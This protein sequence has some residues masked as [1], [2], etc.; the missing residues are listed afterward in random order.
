VSLYDDIIVNTAVYS[1]LD[2][3]DDS[4][5]LDSAYL[6]GRWITVGEITVGDGCHCMAQV[7]QCALPST[8]K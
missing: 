5:R 7:P 1:F 6:G 4:S 2:F 3:I 8:Y